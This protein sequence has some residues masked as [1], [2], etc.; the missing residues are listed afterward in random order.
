MV[1][2]WY[3]ITNPSHHHF[4]KKTHTYV[5]MIAL[6]I[7][8]YIYIYIPW[9]PLIIYLYSVKPKYQKSIEPWSFTLG[10][11]HQPKRLV[12]F[13]GGTKTLPA[14]WRLMAGS[15]LMSESIWIYMDWYGFLS[16]Y[17]IGIY[18]LYSIYEILGIYV[19]WYHIVTELQAK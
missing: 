19:D 9:T 7:D 13:S 14:P 2:L 8:N 10:E 12:K 1:F 18:I 15:R 6:Y 16:T 5:I 3:T 11:T 4:L 17:N